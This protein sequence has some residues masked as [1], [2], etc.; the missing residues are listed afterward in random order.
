MFSDYPLYVEPSLPGDN[1]AMTNIVLLLSQ[2][3]QL[4]GCGGE[5]KLHEG[6]PSTH[7]LTEELHK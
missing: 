2:N 4:L 6:T 3:L 1:T 7:S 5:E